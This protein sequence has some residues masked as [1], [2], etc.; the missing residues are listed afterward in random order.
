MSGNEE[1]TKQMLGSYEGLLDW[2]GQSPPSDH[3]QRSN[4]GTCYYFLTG[5]QTERSLSSHVLGQSIR[6]ESYSSVQGQVFWEEV[7]NP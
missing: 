3:E 1:P 7:Q 6:R 2:C 4:K 5:E